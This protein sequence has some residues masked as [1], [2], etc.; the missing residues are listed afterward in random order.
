MH[1]AKT[2][3]HLEKQKKKNSRFRGGDPVLLHLKAASAY[4]RC[5]Y[6]HW[7]PTVAENRTLIFVIAEIKIYIF[8]QIFASCGGC[9]TD[10]TFVG[11]FLTPASLSVVSADIYSTVQGFNVLV[12][13]HFSQV[14]SLVSFVT[15]IKMVLPIIY[16]TSVTV[17]LPH[18]SLMLS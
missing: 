7:K 16:H 6:A 12:S 3:Q 14:G 8:V 15:Y 17:S 11:G 1:S 4:F 13:V 18:I 9:V 5:F 2:L 10:C